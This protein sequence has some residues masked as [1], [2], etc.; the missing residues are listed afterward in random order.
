MKQTIQQ[1]YWLKQKI[2]RLGSCPNSLL[3]ILMVGSIFSVCLGAYPLINPDEGRYAE[4]SWEILISND[5]L[6]PHLNGIV[7]LD[8]PIL[9]YWLDALFIKLFGINE[10]A[11]RLGPALFGTL[12]CLFIYTAGRNLYKPRVGLIAALILATSPLYFA[13]AH[14]VNMDLAVA[15]L[16]SGCLWSFLIALNKASGWQRDIFLILFYL[17]AG[18]AVL[19]KGLIGIVLPAM[20]IGLWIILLNRWS[21][22]K[23]I[24]LGLGISIF[25]AITLPWYLLVQHANSNFFNYFFVEQQFSR[26]LTNHFNAKQPFWFYLPIILV[27]ILPWG[28]FLIQSSKKIITDLWQKRHLKS[29]EFFLLIWIC[30]IILFFS[31]PSS[32]LIGYILPIYPALILLISLYINNN[33]DK[34]L[35]RSTYY[36]LVALFIATILAA[37]VVVVINWTV[38]KFPMSLRIIVIAASPTIVILLVGI[39]ISLL[40]ANRYQLKQVFISLLITMILSLWSGIGSMANLSLP[41]VKLLAMTLKPSL[42]ASD[43]VLAYHMYYNDLPFYLQR[44]VGIVNDWQNINKHSADNWQR[45]LWYGW[46]NQHSLPLLINEQDFLHAWNSKQRLFLF[47]PYDRYT[48]IQAETHNTAYLLAVDHKV[49]LLSNQK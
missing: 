3:V 29:I 24:R 34:K 10:W 33:W 37:L 30:S 2:V 9:F 36:A 17:F 19:T 49:I 27:G 46:K 28:I 22:L 39:S 14:Y 47:A 43:Q 23:K 38:L 41:S 48:I 4:I 40:I 8:K 1:Y 12:G 18:L 35:S 6:T 25:M 45:E 16:I 21:I 5:Y 42:T 44:R 32:K 15:V 13:F 7:F 26:Y 11:V 31:I 20:V